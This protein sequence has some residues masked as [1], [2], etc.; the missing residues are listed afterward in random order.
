MIE[1]PNTN[2]AGTETFG[3]SFTTALVFSHT[4]RSVVSD[5]N[6]KRKSEEGEGKE[7]EEEGSFI[8]RNING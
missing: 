3:G 4:I 7:E 5:N 8:R 2:T 1:S 6:M